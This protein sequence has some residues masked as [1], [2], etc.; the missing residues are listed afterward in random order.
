LIKWEISLI[1]ENK[2]NQELDTSEGPAYQFASSLQANKDLVQ[3]NNNTNPDVNCT[4]SIPVPSKYEG[5]IDEN[6]TLSPDRVRHHHSEYI[7]LNDHE[8]DSQSLCSGNFNEN[9]KGF[10]RVR[11]VK[12]SRE[13]SAQFIS[14][15][16]DLDP[17]SGSVFLYLIDKQISMYIM[18]FL[19][20]I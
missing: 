7:D 10:S 11:K 6:V 12:G 19:M 17:N 1:D 9:R 14:S 3:E 20:Y 8:I 18:H 13:F 2:R 5:H 15:S 4:N 16:K